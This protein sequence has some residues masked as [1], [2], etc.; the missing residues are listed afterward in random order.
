MPR[1]CWVRSGSST[2]PVIMSSRPLRQHVLPLETSKD[3]T[4]LPRRPFTLPRSS[5]TH[6]RL[7]FLFPP[8]YNVIPFLFPLPIPFILH[9]SSTPSIL[10]IIFLHPLLSPFLLLFSRINCRL[11]FHYHYYFHFCFTAFLSFSPSSSSSDIFPWSI[12]CPSPE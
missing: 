2:Q 8:L 12:R 6:S 3:E 10:P 5:S 1:G 7:L 9:C 4:C 11:K